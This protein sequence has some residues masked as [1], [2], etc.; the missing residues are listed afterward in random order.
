M[1]SEVPE[2]RPALPSSSRSN[3]NT[4]QAIAAKPRVGAARLLRSPL[5]LAGLFLAA[6]SIYHLAHAQFRDDDFVQ[7][8][9]LKGAVDYPHIGPL[10]LY[11]W[12]DG[13]PEHLKSMTA[14]GPAPWFTGLGE[15]H[16]FFRPLGSLLLAA[17]YGVFGLDPAGYFLHSALWYWALIVCVFLAFRRLGRPLE[18]AQGLP[19]GLSLFLFAVAASHFVTVAWAAS[20]WLIVA[21]TMVM[22]AVATH[23]RWRERSWSPGRPISMLLLGTGLLAGEAALSVFAYFVAYEAFIAEGNWKTRIRA[24]ALPSVLVLGYLVFYAWAGFGSAQGPY[25]NP[26]ADP[27]AFA[28]AAPKRLLGFLGQIFVT[29]SFYGASDGRYVPVWG[30]LAVLLLALLLIPAWRDPERGWR[31]TLLWAA[32]G[33]IGSTLPLLAR[34]PS[35]HV[36]IIP[37]IG[38]SA[39][40]AMSL[41]YWVNRLTTRGDSW[42]WLGSGLCLPFVFIH[43]V[44]APYSWFIRSDQWED[45]HEQ[46]QQLYEHPV[47]NSLLADQKAVLLRTNRP[48]AL[49]YTYFYRKV[50]DLPMPESWWV[51]SISGNAQRY[52]RTGPDQLELTAQ[53]GRAVVTSREHAETSMP[54]GHR[55]V[56]LS[57]LEVTPLETDGNGITRVRFRFEQPLESARYRFLHHIDATL[58]TEDAPAVGQSVALPAW[59]RR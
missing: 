46:M 49:F 4:A 9:A 39:I 57:G 27:T 33:M 12:M 14:D 59:P 43:L 10:Q 29:G 16:N 17:D 30:G 5:L 41:R 19:V 23:I 58:T 45:R 50:Y 2:I 54:R 37:T 20:R 44:A 28:A 47:F 8:A 55:T 42:S 1:H 3:A 34:P 53:D 24:L 38:A 6:F 7:I 21:A 18:P 13:K 51:L 32:V 15:I 25:L 22:A 26:L 52:A 48:E 56:H 35:P 31:R 36:L 11:S 40:I